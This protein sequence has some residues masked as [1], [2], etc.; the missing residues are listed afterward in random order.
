MTYP[1][2]TE[3]QPWQG[4]WLQPQYP[5]QHCQVLQPVPD[6]SD[7]LLQRVGHMVEACMAT[8]VAS[9]QI[10]QHQIL[11]KMANLTETVADVQLS[12][13]NIADALININSNLISPQRKANSSSSTSALSSPGSTGG[14]DASTFVD[15]CP[16]PQCVATPTLKRCSAA[17]SLQHMQTCTNLPDG[18]SATARYLSIAEHM[19]LF[20]KQPRVSKENTCCWCGG[21]MSDAEWNPDAKSRHRKS[22]HRVAITALKNADSKV[23]DAMQRQLEQ[24]W[25]IDFESAES[26]PVKRHRIEL[27][28]RDEAGL[29]PVYEQGVGQT[30]IFTADSCFSN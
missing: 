19:L 24:T 20:A 28:K 21:G 10:F 9:N 6:V 26:S 11:Q 2:Y 3:Q 30:T 29:A 15:I 16:F 12:Q 22:C 25:K 7:A 17:H 18:A 4:S 23:A 5:P 13:K 8:M 1:Q 27:G 14:M